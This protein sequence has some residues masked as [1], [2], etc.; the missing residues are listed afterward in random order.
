MDNAPRH[1]DPHTALLLRARRGDARA[2]EQLYAA[3]RPSVEGFV[4]S[5]D[6]ELPAHE[7][8]DL[9]QEVFVRAWLSLANYRGQARGSTFIFGIARN[10][11]LER[12]RAR[13]RERA[14]LAA[15]HRGMGQSSRYTDH[16]SAEDDDLEVAQAIRNGIARLSRKQRQAMELV[17]DAGLS[18][19]QA[20]AV[21]G[22]SLKAFRQRLDRARQAL[23]SALRR[24]AYLPDR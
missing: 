3:L 4:T 21:A 9:V 13:I 17:F 19:L 22:C 24:Q 18:V 8:E 16:A 6:G 20:S 14:K 10:V 1:I 23:R 5:M 15:W 11:M 2:F 7:R 12:L